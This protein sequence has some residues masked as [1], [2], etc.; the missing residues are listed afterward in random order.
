[1]ETA[2]RAAL[3]LRILACV[4]LVV[5]GLPAWAMVCKPV[6]RQIAASS[7]K[8]PCCDSG[9]ETAVTASACC[10]TEAESHGH[11]LSGHDGSSAHKD[12]DCSF[13]VKGNPVPDALAALT[14][15]QFAG[16][17]ILLPVTLPSVITVTEPEPLTRLQVGIQG[18]D[19][20]PPIAS[21]RLPESGRSPPFSRV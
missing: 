19:A 12:S 16:D 3:L 4:A 1:M 20:G 9:M 15:V 18:L 14:T 2:M 5:S 17:L 8:M 10:S 7:C 6:I 13:D 21:P 11:S